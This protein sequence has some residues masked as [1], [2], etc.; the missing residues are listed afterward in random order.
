VM[1]EHQHFANYLDGAAR[2]FGFDNTTRILMHA[3]FGVNTSAAMALASLTSGGCVEIGSA[4]KGIQVLSDA[5][6]RSS[7]VAMTLTRPQLEL[8][9]LQ[10]MFPLLFSWRGVLVVTGDP[11]EGSLLKSLRD[12]A[13]ELR[14]FNQY[15]ITEGAGG[16]LVQEVGL[17]TSHKDVVLLG[18]PMAG[19]QAYVLSN[20]GEIT[21]PGV[22]GDL[23]LGGGQVARGYWN[24]AP[25]TSEKFRPDPFSGSGGRLYV[26][27]ERARRLPDGTIEYRGRKHEWEKPDVFQHACKDLEVA[28]RRHEDV[29]QCAVDK[30]PGGS[31]IAY[32]V[33]RPGSQIN[34]R[35]LNRH[36][37]A[38][39]PGHTVVSNFIRLDS[40]PLSLDGAIDR[41]A[42]QIRANWDDGEPEPG[43]PET[44]WEIRL[45]V[46]WRDLFKLDRIRVDQDFFELGGHSLLALRMVTRIRHEFGMH[47][48]LTTLAERRTIQQIGAILARGHATNSHDALV[49]IQ[50]KGSR[51]PFYCIHPIGGSVFR[52]FELSHSLGSDQ[53]F[54]GVQAPDLLQAIAEKTIEEYAS[55]Y[56]EAIVAANPDGPYLIGGYSFGGAVAFELAQQLVR[57]GRRVALLALL[58][59]HS[60]YEQRKIPDP[61]DALLISILVDSHARM[62]GNHVNVKANDVAA[63]EQN[64]QM[65]FVFRQLKRAGIFDADIPDE[66][67]ADYLE[68]ALTGYKTRSHS[69]RNYYPTIFPGRITLFKSEEL[70]P[71]TRD[72]A[73][74][75]GLDLSDETYGWSKLS[76]EPVVVHAVPGVHERLCHQPNVRVLA[77]RL[78]ESITAACGSEAGVPSR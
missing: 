48:S 40:L 18:R 69:A 57:E 21:Q 77:T 38:I 60:P 68:N 51:P 32:V 1:V 41:A 42:L 54:F 8:L 11:V 20:A 62:E 36:L 56:R 64:E 27:G 39:L 4:R 47:L 37:N 23:F 72:L 7:S 30:K 22:E 24:D 49:P 63:H 15:G 25:A 65:A 6:F 31:V 73:A 28:L 59:T 55:D 35:E 19:V 3:P 67:G 43:E 29:I 58:D 33:P 46:I 14:I 71:G 50:P 9:Q 5:D 75:F 76:N 61:D 13:P 10:A 26:T 12:H 74:R 16:C 70:E 53:P 66:M 44:D 78:A 2:V 34:V 45:A 52:F 17:K